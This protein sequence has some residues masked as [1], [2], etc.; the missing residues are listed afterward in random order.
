MTPLKIATWNFQTDRSLSQGRADAVRGAMAGVDADVWVVTEPLL[1]FSPGTDF[2]LVAHSCEADD[3][4]AGTDAGWAADRRWVAI[5]SR[6]AARKLEVHVEPDRMACARVE[7][8][9]RRDVVVVGTVLPW[10][11]DPRWPGKAEV[12]Y[13]EAV[14]QQAAEWARLWGTPRSAAFCVAGDFNQSLPATSRF[15]SSAGEAALRT[16]LGSLGL[17]CVTGDATD[18]LPGRAGRPSIDHI[19]LG[20]GLRPLG[21]PPSSTW[22]VPCGVGSSAAVTDHYGVWAACQVPAGDA[23]GETADRE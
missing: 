7:L 11:G 14:R 5:W 23:A 2:R 17:A 13:C 4:R 21:D 15:G 6:V 10:P 20:G 1:G 22:D 18:P 16:V 9:G 19:C 12:G 3:I 8:P